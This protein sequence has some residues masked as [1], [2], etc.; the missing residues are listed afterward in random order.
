MTLFGTFMGTVASRWDSPVHPFRVAEQFL[1]LVMIQ[2]YNECVNKTTSHEHNG[3]HAL[4]MNSYERLD[5]WRK[6]CF[7]NTCSKK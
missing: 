4:K 6:I 3:Q 5:A 2:M 1:Y 7:D